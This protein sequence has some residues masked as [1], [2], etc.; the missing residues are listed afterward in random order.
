MFK[1]IGY[2]IHI[3][4]SLFL[5]CYLVSISCSTEEESLPPL[6]SSSYWF[7][8]T[9]DSEKQAAMLWIASSHSP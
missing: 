5:Q 2:I 8:Y 3:H 7:A 6:A 4:A 9:K 1:I